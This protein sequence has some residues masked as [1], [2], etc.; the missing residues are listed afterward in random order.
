[1]VVYFNMQGWRGH[2]SGT[3]SHVAGQELSIVKLILTEVITYVFVNYQL[4]VLPAQFWTQGTSSK[5]AYLC[6]WL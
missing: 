4:R 1:M 6:S 5:S 2:S 3:V